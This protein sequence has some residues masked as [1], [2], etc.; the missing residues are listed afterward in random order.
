MKDTKARYTLRTAPELL[1]KFE[2]VAKFNGRSM[3]K[4]LECIMKNHV[5]DYEQGYEKIPEKVYKHDTEK[6][7]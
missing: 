7:D 2:Y 6:E 3:N 4:E 5:S 1:R